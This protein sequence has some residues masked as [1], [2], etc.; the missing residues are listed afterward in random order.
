[1]KIDQNNQVRQY[2]IKTE[3]ALLSF[4]YQAHPEGRECDVARQGFSQSGL[5]E[6]VFPFNS[7]RKLMRTIIKLPNNHG[8]RVLTKVSV[9]SLLK[10]SSALK[11]HSVS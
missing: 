10:P 6:C 1:M 7:S 3:C 2:G 11:S 5:L 8:Y 4:L 9:F